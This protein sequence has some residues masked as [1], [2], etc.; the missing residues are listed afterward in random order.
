[1][2][3]KY[4]IIF[5]LVLTFI[6]S[7][8]DAT[9]KT[10]T[11]VVN[12]FDNE[13][14]TKGGGASR[15]LSCQII[16]DID[17]PIVA[18]LI[19]GCIIDSLF[20]LLDDNN[21]ITCIDYKKGKIIKQIKTFGQGANEYIQP[22]IITAD[23]E[24]VYLFDPAKQHIMCYTPQLEFKNTIKVGGFAI[25]FIKT[26]DGFL[27][28]CIDGKDATPTINYVSDL[29]KLIKKYKL[30]NIEMRTLIGGANYFF[31]GNN[32]RIFVISPFSDEIYEWNKGTL[33]PLYAYD[34]GKYRIPDKV[35]N[36]DDIIGNGYCFNNNLFIIEDKLMTSFIF[37]NSSYYTVMDETRNVSHIWK[38]TENQDSIPFCPRWQAGNILI[39][40]ERLEEQKWGNNREGIVVFTYEINL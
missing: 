15:I 37:D 7:C 34:F 23:G 19:D 17:N 21:A 32:E 5:F 11:I 16:E 33:T 30:S 13:I 27:F 2:K 12:K 35:T 6:I 9:N 28:M 31:K 22:T 36:S 39:G 38:S 20:Y 3:Y 29:G 25:D 1:M 14:Q 4:C 18:N 8:D 10:G 26:S 40:V 24:S